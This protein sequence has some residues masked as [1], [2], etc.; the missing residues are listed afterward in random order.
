MPL[1]ILSHNVN[2]YDRNKEFIRD[3]CCSFPISVYGLQEHWLRP[4][5]KKYPGVNILKTLHPN[6][7]GWGRSAMKEKMET[8]ILRG[9]PFG[10]TGYIWSKS[11][12]SIVT[13]R[14]EYTHDRVTVIE[15]S[16]AVGPLLIINCYLPY[17][18]AGELISQTN[19]FTDTIG[20][21]DY[22]IN[23]NPDSSIILMGDMNCDFYNGTNQFSL[24]LK[25]LVHEHGLHCTFDSISNFDASSSYTRSNVKQGSFSLLDYM[26]ISK[27]LVPYIVDVTIMDTGD[28]LSDHV[29]IRLSL[30]VDLTQK[31]NVAKSIPSVVNW[32]SIDDN[33]RKNFEK[34]MEESLDNIH[35]PYILH[36]DN[37]CG[38][39]VHIC[40]IEKYHND[41]V[42]SIHTADLQLPRCKP[43]TAK[44]YW[45]DALSSLKHD[46]IVA[47]DYWKLNGSPRTGPIFEA[48]KDAYYKYKL[49]LKKCKCELDQK[50]V[51]SLNED[52]VNGDQ[53]KF[54]KSYKYFNYSKG[55]QSTYI[56]GLND[57]KQIADCFANCFNEIYQTTDSNRSSQLLSEFRDRYDKYSAEHVNDSISNFY[58]SW[59]D[60]LDVMSKLKTGK[61]SASFIKAEHI[62]YG[63]PK[64]AWHLHLLFNAMIQHSY[65]PQDFL[66]G[67]ITPLIKD[68]E[69]DHSDPKNY[70]GLTLGVVFSY[71][72]EHAM[73]IKIGNL[74]ETDSVQF[75]YKKRHSTSHALFSL[76]ECVEYFTSR[77][78]NIFAAFLDCSKGFDKV[79][80][81]GMYIK[82]M[83]RG[84]PLCF[85]NLLIYWYSNLTSFVKWNGVFSGTFRVYSGVRQ[86]G[87]LSPRLFA[88]YIDDLIKQLRSLNVGSHIIDL[89]LACIV[90]DDYICLLVPCCS[91]LQL[92]SWCLLYNPCKS[93]VMHFGK[94]A[95]APTY[96]M[97]GKKL[98]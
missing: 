33:T 98:D 27:N 13:P 70:R 96:T 32:R 81:N 59:N 74:L 83:N 3:T 77:G 52:L 67:V 15:I 31:Q 95:H 26:F 57:D 64:L 12:S 8:K 23:D 34:V 90:Y 46:S 51:D 97:Y 60:M 11:I 1:D 39:A 93:K 56:N 20:F 17:F 94:V 38:D 92:L 25:N 87:V 40:Q 49:Y 22:I 84:I 30:N 85:L 41:I 82:L 71:L 54:W 48:K 19:I 35:V 5:S 6:L 24:L 9:R 75:G 37:C 7:D 79:N 45:N 61:S 78:S 50:R 53:N 47:H 72:F 62:L 55:N 65:V 76:K 18:N 69:G 2:G 44:G 43:T 42:K 66:N 29:P 63:S 68:T 89:F 88:V 36:G 58:L 91:A 14:T 86:G 80:H 28:V 16:T 4:P 10:G 21:I 73:L